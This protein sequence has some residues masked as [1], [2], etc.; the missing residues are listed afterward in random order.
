MNEGQWDDE[1]EKIEDGADT[2]QGEDHCIEVQTAF[3]VQGRP[4]QVE[5]DAALKGRAARTDDNQNTPQGAE[6]PDGAQE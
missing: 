6:G 3:V 2:R 5:M 1:G 4:R